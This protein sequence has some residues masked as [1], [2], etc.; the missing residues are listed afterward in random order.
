MGLNDI[1]KKQGGI[2]L[3]RQYWKGGALFTGLCEFLLLGKSR[4]ALEILRLSTTLKIKQKL[5]KKYRYKL[6]EFD[7]NYSEGNH[8]ISNKIWICWFQGMDNAPEIVKR[9]YNSVSNVFRDKDIILITE[10]N[11]YEYITFPEYIQKKINMGI[12]NSAHLSDLLRL[13]LLIKYGGTWMD[14]TVYCTGRE[15]PKYMIESELFLF[16]CLKPGLDGHATSISNWFISAYTNNKMLCALRHLLYSYWNQNDNV[17]NYFV[18][19]MFFQMVIEKYPTEWNKVIPFSNSTPH[20]LLLRIFD[21]YDEEMWN[22]ITEMT[23]FHKLSYKFDS[24][25]INMKNTFYQRIMLGE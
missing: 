9:C 17:V 7:K 14:A 23:P 15:V 20:I 8:E 10:D 18:F 1:F 13:E 16:Q 11:M 24:N 2:N 6:E 25:Q 3:I 4:T 21:N 19:H 5:E 12:I 22:S